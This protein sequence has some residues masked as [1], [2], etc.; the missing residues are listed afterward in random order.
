MFQACIFSTLP[1]FVVKISIKSLHFIFVIHVLAQLLISSAQN[2]LSLAS[3]KNALMA[4][5]VTFLHFL[6][7]LEGLELTRQN[8]ICNYLN[9]CGALQSAKLN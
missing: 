6:F 5:P 7:P 8:I 9:Q 2:L 3:C 1:F 4:C